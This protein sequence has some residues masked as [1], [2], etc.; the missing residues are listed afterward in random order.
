MRK[1]CDLRIATPLQR[2]HPSVIHDDGKSE[3]HVA[4][5]NSSRGANFKSAAFCFRCVR[6]V[7]AFATVDGDPV[8]YIVAAA[9]GS[10]DGARSFASAAL[11]WTG[12]I[13]PRLMPGRCR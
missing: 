11:W 8:A 6:K 3:I 4:L 5:T 13:V 10:V 1:A 12:R 9:Q 2:I 7:P